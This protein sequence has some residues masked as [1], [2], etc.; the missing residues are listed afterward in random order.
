MWILSEN[1]SK[2]SGNKKKNMVSEI[3]SEDHRG[4]KMAKRQ[5]FETSIKEKQSLLSRIILNEG[6][7]LIS[8]DVKTK[9]FFVEAF[10]SGA[11][12]FK[13]FNRN[14]KGVNGGHCRYSGVNGVLLES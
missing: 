1:H 5:D 14:A 4:L 11:T 13:A 6:D 9:E 3:I 8:H 12:A 10:F 7:F 2:I